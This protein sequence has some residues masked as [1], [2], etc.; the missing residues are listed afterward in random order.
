MGIR[1]RLV[2][3]GEHVTAGDTPSLTPAIYETSTFSMPSA[4]A[5]QAYQAREREGYFYTR[6]DNPT[7]VGVEQKIASLDGGEAALLFSSGQAATTHTLL[8][9]LKAGDEVVC[10]AAIYGGTHHLLTDLLPRLGIDHRFVPV[11]DLTKADRVIGPRTRLVW[12]ESPINPTLR[13][14]DVRAVAAMCRQAGVLSVADNTFASAINQPVLA[15]GVDLC[16]QSATKYLN[17]HSDV[18]AGAVSGSKATLAPIAALRRLMGGVLDPIAAYNLGRGMKTLSL[19]VMQQNATA[20]EVAR[21]LEGDA[22]IR[23]VYY[24]GL[25]SHPDHAVARGQMCGFGGMVTAAAHSAGRQPRRGR[26][27][28]Q[29]AHAVVACRA[30][31]RG[32]GSGW[33]LAGHGAAVAGPRGS[34]RHPGRHQAGARLTGPVTTARRARGRAVAARAQAAVPGSRCRDRA[35]S[36]QP[37]D[38]GV[39]GAHTRRQPRRCRALDRQDPDRG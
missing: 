13:C 23:R 32:P 33:R 16:M 26:E 15:Y 22:R 27:P 34:R 29:P 14:V 38:D 36:E 11:E 6:Y 30:H 12:F 37:G 17:G 21:T 9:L 31:G 24:P 20:L 5:L 25:E 8:G 1:T 35:C 3:V 4:A 7:V 18:T 39:K 28:L 19:R 2:Q 10:S